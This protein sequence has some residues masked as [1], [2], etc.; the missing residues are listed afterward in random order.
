M[1]AEIAEERDD[2]DNLL[3]VD[4]EG[5]P[6]GRADGEVDT[7]GGDGRGSGAGAG[8]G[9]SVGVAAEEAPR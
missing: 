8:A 2:E 5:E 4:S 7:A 3:A 1:L 6:Y 9:V